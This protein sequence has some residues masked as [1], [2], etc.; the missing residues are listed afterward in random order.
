MIMKKKNFNKSLCLN[1]TTITSLSS[2]KQ[3][4]VKGGGE[5]LA[6]TATAGCGPMDTRDAHGSC[7]CL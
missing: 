6:C 4:E 5:T 7:A 1:K 3:R 2:D